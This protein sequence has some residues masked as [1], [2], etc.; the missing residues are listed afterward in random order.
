MV[1]P[2]LTCP[3]CNASLAKVGRGATDGRVACPRCGEQLPATVS[4][5]LSTEPFPVANTA[6]TDGLAVP[7]KWKTL[8][9]IL[10]VMLGMAAVATV[11]AFFTKDF[12]RQNDYR[13]RNKTNPAPRNSGAEVPILGFLPAR[14]N[15]LAALHVGELLKQPATRKLLEAPPLG[16][17]V[18]KLP[19]WTGLTL[20]DID[21]V[22]LGAEIKSKLPQLIV[23]VQTRQAYLPGKITAALA[24]A[25][26]AKYRQK[27][28]VRFPLQPVGEG[29][30]WCHSERLLVFVLA[31]DAVNTDDL[32]AVPPQPRAGTA[33][34]AEPL[35]TALAQRLPT[36]SAFWLAGHFEEPS[37]LGDLL[38]L[39]GRKNGALETLVQS[40]T[41]VVSLQPQDNPTLTAHFFTGDAKTT[42]RLQALLE[43]RRWPEAQSYK[44]AGPPPDVLAAEDQW[45]TLQARGDLAAWI[46][47]WSTMQE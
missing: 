19:Q 2:E 12:R 40:K 13:T 47:S 46:A 35:R 26:P 7:G 8:I 4:A 15:V 44:V 20:G 1:V 24:P 45:V 34:F 18:A 43:A 11:F 32:D 5:Q 22:V 25:P 38:K 21:Q 3:F 37:A 39:A 14:C 36:A 33:G 10:T 17:I 27:T 42:G 28:L 23:L 30:L 9:A 41:F 29:L 16:L 6:R 31:L